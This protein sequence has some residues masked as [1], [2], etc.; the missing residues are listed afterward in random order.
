MTPPAPRLHQRLM[1][2]TQRLPLVLQWHRN[3][4]PRLA[5]VMQ[6]RLA[7]TLDLVGATFSCPHIQ[8]ELRITG[9]D[10]A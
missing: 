2:L 1:G 9:K 8:I 7:K 4:L 6:H 3:L 5:T 10:A